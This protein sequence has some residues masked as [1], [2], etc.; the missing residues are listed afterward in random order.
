MNLKLPDVSIL[1][2]VYKV[3]ENYLR[4]CIE[5]CISQTLD[6]IEIIIVD[7]GSP[8]SCGIICDG[9]AVKDN[10]IKVIHKQNEG[11]SAARNTAFDKA[12]G[13]YIT[14]LDGDDFLER[15]ACERAFNCA[16]K[17]GVQVVLW[18]Q[19]VE[20]LGSRRI[21]ETFDKNEREFKN[22]DCKFLQERVLDF[23][24]RIAQVFCKLINRNFMIENKIRH[25]EV[26]KQGAE[27]LVFNIS[28][29]EHATSVYYLPEPL[30]HY[31]YNENSISHSHDEKNYYLILRCFEYIEKYI[32]NSNNR[33]KMESGL[34][35]RLLYVIVT[36]GITGYFN[37]MNKDK[38]KKKVS[39]YKRFLSEPII[40]RSLK[41]G[42]RSIISLQR[43]II[44]RAIESNQYWIISLLARIRRIQLRIK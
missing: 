29:F 16:E 41:F 25:I 40:Q 26:L 42:N 19:F 35:T 27:G 14:F 2:P 10:R 30:L 5:S 22:E 28:L 15:N 1:I 17:H 39:D 38:Y 8:D 20:Y 32:E 6:D 3:P 9:Y 21:V 24:G 34:Y 37:P 43:K 23:N 4:R 13:K 44:I 36:T 7:D 33:E 18:N 11:L 12:C 31:V